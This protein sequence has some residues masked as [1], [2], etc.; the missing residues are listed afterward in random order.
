MDS[1]AVVVGVVGELLPPQA[2][3][4]NPATTTHTG[5]KRFMRSKLSSFVAEMQVTLGAF[6]SYKGMFQVRT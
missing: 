5:E 6:V 4:H 1:V 3:T 2:P